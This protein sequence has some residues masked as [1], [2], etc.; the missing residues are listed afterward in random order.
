[1]SA[2]GR[3][4]ARAGTSASRSPSTSSASGRASTSKSTASTSASS[5]S[6]STSGQAGARTARTTTKTASVSAPTPTPTVSV[7]RPERVSVFDPST[8]MSFKPFGDILTGVF[9][10]PTEPTGVSTDPFRFI[11]EPEPE[12]LFVPEP[13]VELEVEPELELELEE[14]AC[15]V[16]CNIIHIPTG[17]ISYEGMCSCSTI[18]RYNEDPDY[19][20][21]ITT[22]QIEPEVELEP[23]LELEPEV[24]FEP[25]PEITTVQVEPPG[26]AV[27]QCYMVHGQELPLTQQAVDYYRNIGVTVTP[28]V[29]PPPTTPTP[30]TPTPT[31]TEE[32]PV[33]WIPEPFFSFINEVFGK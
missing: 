24:P 4:T 23:E 26:V 33:K 31:P 12:V 10:E 1:M 16:Y 32:R 11:P 22:S 2:R 6:A 13:E 27:T 14:A 8:E 28:C 7:G 3:T 25:E 18:D 20:V 29:V 5:G 30:T 17:I 19:R 15:P 9:G 21:E